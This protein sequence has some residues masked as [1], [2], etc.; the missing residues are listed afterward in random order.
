[1]RTLPLD[2]NG[3]GQIGAF[4]GDFLLNPEYQRQAGVWST[5]KKQLFIDSLLNSFDTPKI[6]VHD[7][8]Q[9]KKHREHYAIVDGL[10]RLTT[11]WGFL[12]NKFPL[13]DEFRLS[14][15]SRHFER[16]PHPE[17]GQ[18]FEEL[19]SWWQTFFHSINL[20]IMVIET[21]DDA[22]GEIEE[23]F[24]RLNNGQPLT[25]AEQRNAIGGDMAKMIRKVAGHKFFK[26]KVAFSDTRYRHY[27]QAAK[28]ILIATKI[29]DNAD[30]EPW[31]DLKKKH[32]DALVKENKGIPESKEKKLWKQVNGTL[33]QA[34]HLFNDKDTLL[35]AQAMI[36]AAFI[37]T[38]ILNRDYAH[39]HLNT[40]AQG[41]LNDFEKERL[42]DRTLPEEDRDPFLTEYNLKIQQATN[43]LGN[44][45]WRV[46]YLLG[47]FLGLNPAIKTK[48]QKRLFSQE[49][50]RAL[51][52]LGDRKC[53]VCGKKLNNPSD[54][55]A[56]HKEAH[57][58]G[59]QT[60]IGNGQILCQTCN[61]KKG[62]K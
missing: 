21:G 45:Q 46:E 49:M 27:D 33:N 13:A 51:W 41:F 32:L 2:T 5:D 10:Q 53:Q 11:I 31:S 56:D 22:D 15:D 39:E 12:E 18:Y 34:C 1:M 29:L 20:P 19:P 25:S 9:D 50:K 40:K 26:E 48:D 24:S 62:S 23:L 55:E 43:D 52:I 37:F 4:K 8:S 47:Q 6:Y 44:I 54:G 58:S 30:K 17:G 14:P 60:S 36:P 16:D 57:K 28:L 42:Q 35:K 7:L 61:R 3:I 38:Y 59:G